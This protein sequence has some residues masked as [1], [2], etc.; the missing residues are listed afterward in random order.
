MLAIGALI[1]GLTLL[2]LGA[3]WLVKGAARLA[4]RLGMSAFAIGVTVVAFGTSSPELF[5][6]LRAA[7]TGAGDL[8]VG[9][10]L[11][12]NIA[13]VCLILGITALINPVR[14]ERAVIRKEL[15]V[16]LG[17][18]VLAV[19]T[20]L[21]GTVSRIEGGVLALGI[22]AYVVFAYRVGKADPELAAEIADEAR[23][24]TE[25][26]ADAPAWRDAVLIV[27]GLMGLA[28]GAWLLVEGAR[29]IAEDLLGV[30]K[31]VVGLTIV[32]FGTSLPELAASLR[33]V[34]G[35]HQD[36]AVGNIVGS[37]VFNLLCVMGFTAT[38]EPLQSPAMWHAWVVVGTG[39]LCYPVL[40]RDRRIGRAQG[41]LM[42]AAYLV[43]VILAYRYQGPGSG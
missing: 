20:L 6:S 17:I 34:L 35:K 23:S 31:G 30:S 3:D 8:A 1:G 22:V 5:A 33:A 27:S 19:L 10:V 21:D 4:S 7:T 2:V 43:Y 37:N 42:F 38:V 40:R 16:M 11:G 28:L 29:Y 18:T 14:V 13:N 36:I 41:S 26:D 25:S 24:E 32:A 9:N 39:L 12:S 15:P